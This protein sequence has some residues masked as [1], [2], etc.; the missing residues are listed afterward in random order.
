MSGTDSDNVVRFDVPF[1]SQNGVFMSEF[2]AK[3]S[4]LLEQPTTVIFLNDHVLILDQ[5]KNSVLKFD[6]STGDL[7][8]P[9]VNS[10]AGL[11][12]PEEMALGSDGY[13]YISDRSNDRVTRFEAE[14]GNHDPSFAIAFNS[15]TFIIMLENA[16][17]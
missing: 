8:E 7:I 14:T 2:I 10:G 17:P 15:P 13:L 9:L 3:T 16:A 1:D 11:A 12:G 6:A 5:K 4:G